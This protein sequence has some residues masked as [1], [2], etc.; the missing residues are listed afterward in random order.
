M[1]R[2]LMLAMIVLVLPAGSASAGAGPDPGA[3]AA[4]KYW[5]AFA[6]LPKFTDAE[7][8]KLV[9]GYL[10]LPLDAQAREIVTKAEYALQMLHH[11]AALRR[12]DW[13]IGSDEGIYARLPHGPGVRML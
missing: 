3:N 4:L 6:T 1:L 10:T 9:A 11:G 12:C 5:Q 7:Q 8:N 2:A 13:G